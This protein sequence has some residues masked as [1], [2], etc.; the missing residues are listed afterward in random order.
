MVRAWSLTRKT[1]VRATSRAVIVG[2]ASEGCAWSA[3]TGLDAEV[4]V[5]G[6]C[7][8]GGKGMVRGDGG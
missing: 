4:A 7:M 1:M 3:W 8:V 6:G 5:S 2:V